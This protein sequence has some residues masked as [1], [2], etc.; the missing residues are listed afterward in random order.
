LTWIGAHEKDVCVCDELGLVI[1]AM[2]MDMDKDKDK[3]LG[4]VWRWL[5]CLRGCSVARPISTAIM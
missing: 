3:D 4:I 1:D 5:G 2:V